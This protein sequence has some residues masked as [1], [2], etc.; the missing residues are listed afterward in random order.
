MM[1]MNNR[2]VSRPEFSPIDFDAALGRKRAAS[3]AYEA[4]QTALRAQVMKTARAMIKARAR[5]YALQPLTLDAIEKGLSD[6]P[7]KHLATAIAYIRTQP[8]RWTG[9]GGEVYAI[10]LRGAALYAR[11][12]RA[13]A[14]RSARNR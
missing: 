6:L 12:A 5:A 13:V 2:G 3:S 4:T 11:F 9:F 1:N 14:S 7:P 10:N 8:T